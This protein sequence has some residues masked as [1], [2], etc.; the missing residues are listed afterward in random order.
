MS[1]TLLVSSS[2]MCHK[3]E[4]ESVCMLQEKNNNKQTPKLNSPPGYFS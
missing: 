3:N 4:R 1:V 2:Y